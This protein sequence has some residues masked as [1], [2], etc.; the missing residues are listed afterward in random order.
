MLTPRSASA[1]R[2]AGER[3]RAIVELDREPDRHADTS[4]CARWYRGRP[5]RCARWLAW[6]RAARVRLRC[7]PRSARPPTKKMPDIQVFGR[8]DSTRDA[9]RA[10][11]LPRAA[12]RRPLRRPPKKPIARRRAAAV[13]RPA[14][15]ARRCSTPTSRAYRDAG[16]A[17]LSTDDAGITQRLLADAAPAPAAARPLRQ[18]GHGRQGRGDLEGLAR[19]P[20]LR[21]GDAAPARDARAGGE[22]AMKRTRQ[23]LVGSS[24]R[25]MN[26]IAPV[27]TSRMRYTN[28][29]SRRSVLVLERGRL[30]RSRRSCHRRRRSRPRPRCPSRRRRCSPGG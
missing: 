10:P 6:L 13:R 26:R 16:L 24:T 30:A 14:R 18:R 9:R 27:R 15:R 8:D 19:P 5:V 22:A 12:D 11:V 28:G 23:R 3:A 25:P 7:P 4:C 29:R 20:A 21:A 17:Y 2:D 1:V